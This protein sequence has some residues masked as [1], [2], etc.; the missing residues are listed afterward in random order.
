MIEADNTSTAEDAEMAAGHI[1][2]CAGHVGM[3]RLP[4]LGSWTAACDRT[5]EGKEGE[6]FA[7]RP[8]CRGYLD[9]VRMKSVRQLLEE[10]MY[11]NRRRGLVV[12]QSYH[13]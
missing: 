12:H 13:D 3:E 9:G 2:F 11:P 4:T 10:T 1:G 6:A 8:S 5:W 7:R